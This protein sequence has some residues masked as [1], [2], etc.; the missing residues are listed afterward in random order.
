MFSSIIINII[1]KTQAFNWRN[2]VENKKNINIFCQRQ[3][4]G[5][6]TMTIN[7]LIQ[8]SSPWH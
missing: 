8:G 7:V 1:K 3:E 4:K 5:D 6:L 2:N